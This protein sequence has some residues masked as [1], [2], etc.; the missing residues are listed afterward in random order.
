MPAE[1]LI[2]EGGDNVLPREVVFVKNAAAQAL[3][4]EVRAVSVVSR[5]SLASEGEYRY[6]MEMR[7]GCKRHTTRQSTFFELPAWGRRSLISPS[8]QSL[9][10]A[11]VQSPPTQVPPHMPPKPSR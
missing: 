11:P 3:G 2:D 4:E 5:S 9:T 1:A 10:P 6:A 8:P 7:R